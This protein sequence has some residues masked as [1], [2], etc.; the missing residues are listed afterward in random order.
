[1]GAWGRFNTSAR[2]PRLG[3]HSAALTNPPPILLPVGW[4][5]GQ[6]WRIVPILGCEDGLYAR[7]PSADE[8][9]GRSR[10]YGTGWGGRWTSGLD[11]VGENVRGFVIEGIEIER[12]KGRGYH[13]S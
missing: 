9:G 13:V 5:W 7:L 10:E 2:S 1:M 11:A 3:S 12:I 6:F 8:R 4:D